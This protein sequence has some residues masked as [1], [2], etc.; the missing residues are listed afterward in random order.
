MLVLRGYNKRA[1]LEDTCSSVCAYGRLHGQKVTQES[2]RCVE[3]LDDLSRQEEQGREHKQST[4]VHRL[5]LPC[6]IQTPY[7][8]PDFSFH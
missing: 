2:H 7:R 6:K 3:G 8:P 5:D 1:G 4:R